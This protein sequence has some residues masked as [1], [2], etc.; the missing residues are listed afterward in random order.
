MT[1]GIGT[2]QSVRE[3][4]HSAGPL[5]QLLLGP[6][7][8]PLTKEAVIAWVIAENVE[9][10]HEMR[11]H[12]LPKVQQAHIELMSL[13]QV[14]AALESRHNCEQDPAE[15]KHMKKELDALRVKQGKAQHCRDHQQQIIECCEE[16]LVLVGELEHTA[17]SGGTPSDAP[18]STASEETAEAPIEA[19]GSTQGMPPLEEDME[20]GSVHSPVGAAT[21]VTAGLSE[22][23]V[24]SPR[25]QPTPEP[26]EGLT[27]STPQG[28]A[29]DTTPPMVE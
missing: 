5:L 3:D 19:S 2:S 8:S 29:S 16:D 4:E 18:T 17:T 20:V 26:T 12:A 1:Q 9:T 22:L 7:T 10:L 25:A 6:G 28:P 21:G 27:T 14:V 15:C 23:S 24:S 13:L 11:W